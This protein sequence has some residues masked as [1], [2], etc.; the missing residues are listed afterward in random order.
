M[1]RPPKGSRIKIQEKPVRTQ[2]PES[3]ASET[4]DAGAPW[5]PLVVPNLMRTLRILVVDDMEAVVTA[6][7]DGLGQVGHHVYAAYS[8]SQA[9]EIFR[10][11]PVD[12]I[13]CDLVMPDMNGFAVGTAVKAICRE[14]CARK[15]PFILFTGFAEEAENDPRYI[16]S[17]VDLVLAKPA[18][19]ELLL[20][21]VQG[22]VPDC[23]RF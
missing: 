11:M 14:R 9:L 23:R 3:E 12:A 15:T 17:G 8:G 21:A 18:N 16:E 22:I 10:C 5:E 19:L 20:E 1:L 13:I 2:R 4:V 6:L 7:Q